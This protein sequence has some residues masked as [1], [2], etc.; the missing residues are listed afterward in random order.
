MKRG[1]EK[2]KAFPQVGIADRTWP[3]KRIESAPIWCSVDLRD[4]NQALVTPMNFA[5]KL[6]FFAMLVKMGFKE[7]EVG[8][9][10]ASE[11]EYEIL[12]A[13]IEQ[14]LIPEDVTLQV[15]VQAREHLIRKTYES[16]KGA[17]NVIVHFYNSTSTLQRK[18]VFN[19]DQQ[20]ITDIAVAGAKLIKELGDKAIAEG[21]NIRYE[22][23]PESFTGTELDF[24]LNICEA[25]LDAL[26]ADAENRVILNLPATVEMSTP[27]IYADQI[28]YFCRNL[29]GRERAIISLHPHND[30]GT[31]VASTELGLLA[32]A[33]RV[34]GTVFGNGERTG[35]ADIV[36]IA[37]NMFT[38]GID[39][40]LNLTN[41]PE[42]RKVF[43]HNT[44]MQVGERHPYVGTLVFTAFSGSHQDAINKGLKYRKNIN[45]D[46]WEVPYLPIDP[47]DVGREYEPI[48]R[49]NSQ[50]GKGGAAF[51]M[52]NDFGYVLPK[53][54]HPEFGAVIKANCD[55]LGRELTKF[56]IFEIF[57][58][59]YVEINEP[60]RL[61]SQKVKF[62]ETDSGELVTY[63][64]IIAS[65]KGETTIVG[66]GNGP[67]D[68]FFKA[69][70]TLGLDKYKFVSYSEH[71]DSTG[72]D[73][74]AIAYIEIM[75]PNHQSI[76]GVG[77]DSSIN[78]A[79][80]KGV[81]SAI[82]RA[83]ISE[84]E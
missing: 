57:N 75:K 5:Q 35:N 3:D 84:K 54:M 43:E 10:S 59:E 15:L 42:V 16:I 29:K 37:L 7:I 31:C 52:E 24:A 23:S 12:R 17:K 51:I 46:I 32:G 45:S 2:Y 80:I 66:E 25:V 48:I 27:N 55:K 6:E 21:T 44:G 77:I 67:I 82:N 58:K 76:Y 19:M 79:S 22:Y 41:L 20:G 83:I 39:P 78:M 73:A 53:K 62:K 18:A 72:S 69:L 38:Q 36:N 13:L 47:A 11:T 4:G 74:K 26:E 1:Y 68:A 63:E 49:I 40:K 30:R 64:G 50:S 33:E 56:E 8:F 60:Y 34:E 9:P 71:A 81:I 70:A 61:V 14:N 65:N 28:E